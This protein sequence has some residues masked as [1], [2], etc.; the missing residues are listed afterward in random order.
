MFL[1]PVQ[2]LRFKVKFFKEIH[3]TFGDEV[4]T[5]LKI[6]TRH[7]HEWRYGEMKNEMYKTMWVIQIN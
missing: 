6:Y 4:R 2:Q 5:E 1:V 3:L 7:L